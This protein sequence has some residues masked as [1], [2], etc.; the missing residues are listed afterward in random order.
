MQGIAPSA[1]SVTAAARQLPTRQLVTPALYG[2]WKMEDAPTSEHIATLSTQMQQAL[3]NTALFSVQCDERSL[4]GSTTSVFH[5]DALEATLIGDPQ[6]QTSQLQLIAREQGHAKALIEAYQLHGNT[7]IQQI[8]GAFAC[9]IFDK[10][11]QTCLAAVDR[12]STYPIYYALHDSQLWI[13]SA[14]SALL[15]GDA[16]TNTITPQGL[17]NFVF[18]HMVPS[19][20]AI[21]SQVKKLMAGQALIIEKGE[22]QTLLHWQPT[23]K[24]SQERSEKALQAQLRDK[25]KAAVKAAIPAHSEQ[26]AAFLSGGLDSSTVVGMLAELSEGKQ[27]HAYSI[28]FSAEGYDEMAYARITAKHFGVELHEYYVTPE[29]VVE[30]LPTV[31]T[32]YDEPFGNSSALPAYFCAKVA[33][34]SGVKH[35]LAGDGGDEFF[36]GNERY[37][38]QKVFEVYSHIP[39][40]LRGSMLEPV[41]NR[42]PSK[43]PMAD[44]ARSY[45]QQANV[46]LPGR[47][48]TYN[49]LKRHQPNEIFS[50]AFIAQIDTQVP[51]QLL[52]QVYDAPIAATTLDR[53]LY[54]DWQ[55]TLADNDIRK[56]SHMCALAGVTVSYPM[57]NDALVDFSCTLPDELKLKGQNLRHFYKRALTGWL[58]DET[59]NKTKQGFGLPFGVWMQT[60][61]PLRDMAYECLLKIK[62]RPYFRPEF[63]DH[64]IT[65]H[66]DG[67]AAYYGELIWILTVLEIWLS[68]HEPS[69]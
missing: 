67:H 18:F 29:D 15:A 47:L 56:V 38:K 3:T 61:A 68:H 51:D 41:I 55:F 64:L 42:I 63:I 57:L 26:T 30:A 62:Q 44:K 58:P 24:R 28:G 60:H 1:S 31:A 9:V 10:Q 12:F 37:A 20:N 65:L 39:K 21:F 50:D 14:A 25:L 2:Y 45:I 53:M 69:V 7:C 6:W 13:A 8:S 22:A 5:T 59:I 43:I 4:L 34:Q 66:K 54:L 17:Y 32:S 36:A 40:F 52:Q 16:S 49:F 19:P 23:F 46:G 27:A 35:L 33:A 48:H 11:K